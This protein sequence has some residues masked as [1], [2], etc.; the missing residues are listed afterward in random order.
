MFSAAP[1]GL[2]LSR[3]GRGRVATGRKEENLAGIAKGLVESR[4]GKN[5]QV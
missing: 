3:Y 2:V 4:Q 5:T 1:L